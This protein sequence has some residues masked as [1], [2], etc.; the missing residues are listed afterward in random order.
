MKLTPLRAFIASFQ[1]FVDMCIEDIHEE[2]W[3]WKNIFWQTDKVFNI[4]N[5]YNCSQK[6]NGLILHS[7]WNQLLLELPL[8]HFNTLQL[9]TSAVNL[10]AFQIE[11]GG[12]GGRSSKSYLLPNFISYSRCW[13]VC[14][15]MST[16]KTY[17]PL[18]LL[19]KCLLCH[20]VYS[21]NVY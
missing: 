10:F 2:V 3:C 19:P 16:P 11:G 18:C 21:Q 6:N 13:N 9:F 14:S 8:D 4:A 12:G 1:H 15:K 20:Y 17:T 7:V 5:L